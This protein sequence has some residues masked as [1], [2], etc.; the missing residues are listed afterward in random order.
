MK[1]QSPI[2]LLRDPDV[3]PTA[4][5]IAEA[6]GEAND[7]YKIFMSELLGHDIRLLWRYY[8]DG[9]AWLAKGIYEWTG[10]RG[11]Q[12]EMTVFWLSIWEGFFQVTIYIPEKCRE[13]VLLLPFPEDLRQMIIEAKQMGERLKFFPVIFGMRSKDQLKALFDLMDYKKRL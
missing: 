7:T 8:K 9:K 12:K 11:G 3:P 4:D 2:L 6:I 10:V 1:M 5:V 13:A